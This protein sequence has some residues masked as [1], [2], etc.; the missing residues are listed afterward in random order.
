MSWIALVL[1]FAT[2]SDIATDPATQPASGTRVILI[3]CD[4]LRPD[5]I[6]AE[7]APNLMR[8]MSEGTRAMVAVDEL[9]PITLPNHTSMLTGLTV[10]KHGIY[11]NNARPGYLRRPTLFSIARA[12][13]FRCAF[14][15][16][17]DK[18]SFLVAPPEAIETS[19][20]DGDMAAVGAKVVEQITPAG[21]H[22]IFL[23][24]REPD[25]TGHAKGW[26]SPEYLA[27]VSR[28]DAIVGDILNAAAADVSRPTYILVTADHGGEGTNHIWDNAVTRQIPWIVWGPDIPRNTV[29]NE[30]VSVV[31]T[32]PTILWL[33]GIGAPEGLNG[34]AR[35]GVKSAAAGSSTQPTAT[36]PSAPAAA[37]SDQ[38]APLGA[39]NWITAPI[40]CGVAMVLTATTLLLFVRVVGARGS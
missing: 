28:S 37:P 27:A 18:F 14:F 38:L 30:T 9:P 12:A 22:V 26:M 34:V 11:F 31:D 16:S 1:L 13:G 21:P 33:L 7:T 5:A 36:Q 32:T 25:S 24:L 19:F 20:I 35:T 39:L 40:G 23:H 15:A 17:K 6:S 8:M 4:G 29:L 10:A 3:S 2:P